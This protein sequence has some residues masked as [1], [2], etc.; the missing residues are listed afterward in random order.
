MVVSSE[1]ERI[2]ENY[3]FPSFHWMKLI[4][5]RRFAE[6]NY[7]DATTAWTNKKRAER[8]R[9]TLGLSLYAEWKNIGRRERPSPLYSKIQRYE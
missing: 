5:E 6:K 7:N 9:S 2:H 1:S 8:E 4:V 3:L